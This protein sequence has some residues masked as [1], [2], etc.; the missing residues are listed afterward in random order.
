VLFP[1]RRCAR[2]IGRDEELCGRRSFMSNV[3]ERVLS[4]KSL[5]S[6][7]LSPSRLRDS[8]EEAAPTGPSPSVQTR[9]RSGVRATQARAGWESNLPRLAVPVTFALAFASPDC[10]LSFVRAFVPESERGKPILIQLAT[11]RK[12]ESKEANGWLAL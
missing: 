11:W 2:V 4:T 12:R 9:R 10:L 5:Y 3:R 1:W 8:V 7:S 6:L